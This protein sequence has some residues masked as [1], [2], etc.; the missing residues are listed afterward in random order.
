VFS[1]LL[2]NS[3]EH[4]FTNDSKMY[5][6]IVTGRKEGRLLSFTIHDNG[7]FA[8]I[9]SYFREDVPNKGLN[10]LRHRIRNELSVR[11]R[12]P[13]ET[14]FHVEENEMNGTTIKFKYPYAV[15]TKNNN[16]RR[17]GN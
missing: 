4:G 2:E 3:L 14:D 5:K 17:Q 8:G 12:W 6:F 9:Q 1:T 15:S 7:I 11:L 16:S 10:F 13:K